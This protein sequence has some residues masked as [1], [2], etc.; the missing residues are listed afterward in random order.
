M[1]PSLL[2]ACLL[3]VAVCAVSAAAQ[4]A[5]VGR[6][7][8]VAGWW[9]GGLYGSSVVARMEQDGQMLT[10]VVT[11]TGLGGQKDLYHVAGAVFGNTMYVLHGA[12]HVFEGEVTDSRAI[13]GILTTAGGKKLPL[14]AQRIPP[15]PDADAHPLPD[16]P[17][18]P[19]GAAPPPSNG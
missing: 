9:E 6:D 3:T 19:E 14:R 12:G 5:T 10:G 16:P 17:L 1:K 11:V 18:T 4:D 15:P 2:L 7:A 8:E 13:Q